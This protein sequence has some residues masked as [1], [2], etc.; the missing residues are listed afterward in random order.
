VRAT[1]RHDGFV[2]GFVVQTKVVRVNGWPSQWQLKRY[3][4]RGDGEVARGTT[5]R[6][7]GVAAL[8]SLVYE[9]F[10]PYDKRALTP[11]PGVDSFRRRTC[12]TLT[13]RL[14]RDALSAN[15]TRQ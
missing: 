15:Q 7:R 2:S 6:Q 8:C 11:S 10:V 4:T 12:P 9:A 3:T 14:L 1:A 13:S 5:G